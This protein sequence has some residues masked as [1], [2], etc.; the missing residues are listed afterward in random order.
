MDY[1]E[2]AEFIDKRMRMA[3]VYQPVMLITLLENEGQATENEIARALLSHDIAQIE[4]YETITRNMVGRV[5]RN[6]GIVKRDRRTRTSES[7]GIRESHCNPNRVAPRQ[8]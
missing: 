8:M 3:H 2:L 6:H 4:Y 1:E 7:A 5:L